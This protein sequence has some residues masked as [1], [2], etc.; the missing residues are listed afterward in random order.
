[1]IVKK[2]TPE[3]WNRIRAFIRKAEA[4]KRLPESYFAHTRCEIELTAYEAF[5]CLKAEFMSINPI[6]QLKYLFTRE[7]PEVTPTKDMRR[8]AS[9]AL[10]EI[11]KLG[12]VERGQGIIKDLGA[13]VNYLD[14][15]GKTP[16]Y[17]A[18]RRKRLGMAE[19]LLQNGADMYLRGGDSLDPLN[20]ACAMGFAQ[21]ISLFIKHGGDINHPTPFKSWRKFHL[22]YQTFYAYPLAV[23][24]SQD[25]PESCRTL[26]DKGADLDLKIRPDLTIREFMEA[27][28]SD[29]PPRMQTIVRGALS[30]EK[31]EVLIPEVLPPEPKVVPH[32]KVGSVHIDTITINVRAKLS[33]DK[34]ATQSQQIP[35]PDTARVY[36]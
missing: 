7:V 9:Q 6:V 2:H 35:N 15:S 14:S 18:I 13:D 12:Q 27:N 36:D 25:Q 10:I 20:L 16:L 22:G 4:E 19:M 23:A 29:M 28:L 34:V 11:A 17:H 21:G 24:V 3:Q 26:L 33:P 5:G 1:M 31:V 32:T 30:G 8:C